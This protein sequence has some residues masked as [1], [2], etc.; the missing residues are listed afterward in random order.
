[1]ERAS[2]SATTPHSG[3]RY[4]KRRPLSYDAAARSCWYWTIN[5]SRRIIPP[6]PHHGFTGW[7]AAG[8][9]GVNQPRPHMGDGEAA[10][11][12]GRS[13]RPPGLV[14]DA[15][16]GNGRRI[17]GR[18]ETWNGTPSVAGSPAGGHPSAGRPMTH[19]PDAAECRKRRPVPLVPDC[20]TIRAFPNRG[21]RLPIAAC[22]GRSRRL[23]TGM[24]IAVSGVRLGPMT[25]LRE[26]GSSN[27]LPPPAAFAGNMS[28]RRELALVIYLCLGTKSSIS[29]AG[30]SS[31]N[32]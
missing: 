30:P 17:T 18:K 16:L 19:R 21:A 3:R 6:E 15:L 11:R 2:S 31:R 32:G 14:A 13:Q 22:A 8:R 27:S 10:E 23:V 26:T 4:R 12:H 28:L 1:V 24:K 9:R 20:R 5:A 29:G 25:P 7:A